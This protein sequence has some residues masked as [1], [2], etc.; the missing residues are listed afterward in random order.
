M[1]DR[2]SAIGDDYAR[3]PVPFA[4][5]V[6]IFRMVLIVL[7]ISIAL[8]AFVMGAEIGTALGVRDTIL[9]CYLGG[10]VLALIAVASGVAGAIS[11]VSSY[12]MIVHAFGSGGGRLINLALGFCVLGWFGVVAVMFGTTVRQAL[13]G[14]ANDPLGISGWALIG[15]VLFTATTMLGFKA[16]DRLSI[17][18]TPL[19]VTLLVWTLVAAVAQHG[20]SIPM[21]IRDHDWPTLSRWVSFVVGGFAGS[22]ALG[23]D[24]TRYSRSPQKAGWSAL[25]AYGIGFPSI[26]ILAAIPSIVTG[27]RDYVGIMVAL[28]LGIPAFVAVVFAAWTTD[29]YNLYAGSLTLA[30]VFTRPPRWLLTV[31]AGAVG[32]SFGLLG[33]SERVVP[34]LV[35]LSVGVPP[36]AGVYLSCFYLE[37]WRPEFAAGRSETAWRFE[38]L[39]AW[40]A[41]FGFAG[42]GEKLGLTLTTNAALDSLL[43]AALLYVGL[44]FAGARLSSRAARA[45]VS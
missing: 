26:L 15:C 28:G 22:A 13:G 41:G 24:L 23:P 2:N 25:I 39:L 1:Q 44:R 20:G 34:F 16:L 9:A 4:T 35:L 31:V 40:A 42:P 14:A 5:G 37:R 27:E 17:V 19:K 43:V 36:V 3:E 30:T 12:V 33:L 45:A 32:T 21:E 18:V 11:R 7:A 6:G 10:A 29:A 8:P 38:A